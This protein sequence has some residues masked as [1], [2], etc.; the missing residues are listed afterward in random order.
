MTVS[1]GCLIPDA[2]RTAVISGR[3]V[4]SGLINVPRDGFDVFRSDRAAGLLGI[5]LEHGRGFA[6][7]HQIISLH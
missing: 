5:G 2:Q 7:V 3:R 1:F 4:Q 6:A